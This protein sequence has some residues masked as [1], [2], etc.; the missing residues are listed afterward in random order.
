LPSTLQPELASA[1]IT[2]AS[3]AKPVACRPK[4]KKTEAKSAVLSR[5]DRRSG[6]ARG[7]R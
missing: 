7:L 5:V 2:L 1:S 3:M 4:P 6:T